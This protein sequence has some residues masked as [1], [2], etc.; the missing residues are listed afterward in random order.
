MPVIRLVPVVALLAACSASIRGVSP[1]GDRTSAPVCAGG[2]R[3]TVDYVTAGVLA[4][5]GLI[6]VATRERGTASIGLAVMGV[7]AIDAIVATKASQRRSDC[8]AA[9]AEWEA[10]NAIRAKDPAGATGA[11]DGRPAPATASRPGAVASGAAEQRPWAV[12]ISDSAQAIALEL[13]RTGNE[14]FVQAQYGDALV[15]YREAIAYWDHP[16]IHF[17][18]AVCLIHLDQPVEAR[19]HLERS[20]E[21]GEAP[22]GADTYAQGEAY[23]GLLDARL[24]YVTIE[25]P[26]PDENVMLDGKLVLRGPGVENAYVL[27]G[28]HQL[29]A[30]KP[31][32]LPASRRIFVA[33]GH[34]ATFEIHPIADPGVK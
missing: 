3:I 29:V 16:G 6:A 25:C 22:L 7:A 20:L 32:F 27:P 13:Y 23:R 18:M 17:N 21:Y 8:E 4:L 31:G 15:K 14:S 9:K 2:A 1:T 12:G 30:T 5:G 10:S 11:E 24:A 19:S 28:E 34:R 33:A 26:E